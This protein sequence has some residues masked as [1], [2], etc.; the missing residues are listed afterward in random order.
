MEAVASRYLHLR[1]GS[2]YRLDHDGCYRSHRYRGM[3]YDV[4]DAMCYWMYE[5]VFQHD[6]DR[7]DRWMTRPRRMSHVR[8]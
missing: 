2:S 7:D 8:R 4:V 1:V 3:D 5:T 6:E